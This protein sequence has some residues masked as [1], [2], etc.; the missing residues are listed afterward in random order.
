MRWQANLGD[1]LK[2]KSGYLLVRRSFRIDGGAETAVTSYCEKFTAQGA[3]VTLLCENWSGTLPEYVQLVRVRLYGPR[4]IRLWLFWFLFRKQVRRLGRTCLV[5]S[6]EYLL[7]CDVL[8]LGDGL[9]TVWFGQLCRESGFLRRFALKL[10]L[11]HCS[12]MW[13]ERKSLNSECLRQVIV[14]SEY[15]ARQV[16]KYYPGLKNK[17]LIERNQIPESFFDATESK[18]IQ[19]SLLKVIFVGS[20]FRRKGLRAVF[21]ALSQ[22]NS[23]KN[24]QLTIYGVDKNI[25]HYRRLA[26]DFGLIQVEFCGVVKLTENIYRQH[27]VLVLPSFYDPFPNAIAEAL[28][29]G[30]FVICSSTTGGVDFSHEPEIYIADDPD[31][32]QRSLIHIETLFRSKIQKSRELFYTKIFASRYFLKSQK[33]EKMV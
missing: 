33:S 9:H 8:R 15:I 5:Q 4:L 16:E 30:L 6:H 14:N 25:D 12:K 19:S 20:G 22:I 23:R 17:I 21:E 13:M 28:V 31:S 18:R 32:I 24:Y 1:Y 29:C 26:E 2:P 27:D 11:F 7:D 3:S 10:S